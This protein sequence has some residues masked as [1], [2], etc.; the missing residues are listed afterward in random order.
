[1]TQNENPR[2]EIEIELG[3]ATYRV[4][5][6]FK[7]ISAIEMATNQ[8][9]TALGAKFLQQQGSLTEMAAILFHVLR[10]EKN[11]PTQ[12][13][14]Q[15]MVFEDGMMDLIVPIAGLLTRSLR[16]NKA[17]IDTLDKP[18]ENK[19]TKKPQRGTALN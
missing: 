17:Y 19:T 9:C 7:I 15:E 13:E 11:A 10:H 5:P 8:G 12:E 3:G 4:R 16:G 14:I 1:M 6:T 18:D 2:D